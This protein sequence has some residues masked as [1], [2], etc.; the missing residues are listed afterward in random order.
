SKASA[1]RDCGDSP[2]GG[3]PFRK[4]PTSLP[5]LNESPAPCQRTTRT[6]GSLSASARIC[7]SRVYI[8]SVRAFLRSGRF[9]WTRR[10][11]SESSVMMSL[12]SS[13]QFLVCR[14]GSGRSFVRFRQ[15]AA[16]AQALDALRVE[17]ELGEDLLI[18]LA[19]AGR[20]PSRSLVDTV[21][22]DRIAD[23]RGQ[24]AGAFEWNDDVIR[25][26][27]RV[28]DDLLRAVDGAEG[29]VEATEQL[30]PMCHGLGGEDFV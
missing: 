21:H 17:A 19:E 3:G 13:L 4:S 12:M 5:A 22:P 24:L 23:C 20:T 26:Q 30:M 8:A 7:V 28:G 25:R 18:V 2:G 10:M 27:L 14:G 1:K 6:A 16:F 9:S 15:R 29:D 11:P